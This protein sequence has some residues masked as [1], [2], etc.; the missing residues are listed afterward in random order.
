MSNADAA[1]ARPVLNFQLSPNFCSWMAEQQISLAFT[2]YQS[3]RLFVLGLDEADQLV[4][5]ERGFRRCMGLFCTDQ[6]IWIATEHQ[7]WRLENGLSADH[8]GKYD[9]VFVPRESFVT[10]TL[11]A[12]D[13][14]VDADERIVLVN[15]RFSCL[16]T[17]NPMYHFV[18]V[19][20]P[21]FI[22]AI[23][24]GDRCHLNGLALRDGSPRYVTACG[25]ND[26]PEGWRSTAVA[27]SMLL[28]TSWC[29]MACACPIRLGGTA[30]SSG[31]STQA[32]GTSAL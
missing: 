27:S 20:K 29:S 21:P 5:C 30:T 22:S 9:R 10:G 26:A 16:A 19:W 11:D 12:H 2:T 28:L 6:T 18:P 8:A 17:L 7:V 1:P 31:C 3:S 23:A 14:V 24:A 25:K 32:P 13:L 4:S 15:T